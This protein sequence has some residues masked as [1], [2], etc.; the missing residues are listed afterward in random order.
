[1]GYSGYGGVGFRDGVRIKALSDVV[2]TPNLDNLGR[3]GMIPSA[4]E[5]MDGA[6]YQSLKDMSI[7]GHVVLGE[8]PVFLSL[9]KRVYFHIHVLGDDGM[10]REI[11]EFDLVGAGI[12][13]PDDLIEIED[14]GPDAGR[15][16]FD[17]WRLSGI[18]GHEGIVRFNVR[19]HVIE[20]RMMRDRGYALHARLI[21][22]D[23]VVWS[24]FCGSEIGEGW[25]EE[26]TKP[27]LER[28]LTAFD[29]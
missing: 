1:M 11:G 24:G 26:D 5:G 10:F 6:T 27:H 15:P 20:L 29:A 18:D 8:G 25:D 3:A 9:Y 19:D 21:Q 2:L 17:S 23:G 13:L 7:T 16:K 22:P 14:T 28:H 12:D 4:P